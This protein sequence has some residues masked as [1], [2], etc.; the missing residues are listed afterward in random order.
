MEKII[1][2]FIQVLS[3]ENAILDKLLGHSEEKKHIIILGEIQELDKLLQKE[4][5]IAT[6][7]EKIEIARLQISQQIAQQW[8]I[9]A[10]AMTAE[11]I[12]AKSQ[13]HLPSFTNQLKQEIDHLETTIN[14]L[15]EINRQNNELIGMSLDY[16]DNMQAM[17]IGDPAGTYSEKGQ[18]ASDNNS[19]PAF[20]IIDKK[21]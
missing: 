9:P 19:R 13:E 6:N 14:S 16:I 18:Q 10:E 12:I 21:A 3:Q 11:A 5:V 15:R 7:L 1:Q 17:L 2:E 4:S 20:R 8:D